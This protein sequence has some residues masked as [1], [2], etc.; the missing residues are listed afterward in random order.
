MNAAFP[1]PRNGRRAGVLLSLLLLGTGFSLTSLASGPGKESDFQGRRVLFMGIDGCRRDV[2]EQVIAD[3]SAPN[4]AKLASGGLALMNMEAGGQPLGKLNQPTISGPGWSTLL[5]G[6]FASK[7][8]VLGN[9]PKFEA[10]NFKDHPH[11]FRY[12]RQARPGAWLGSVVGDTWPEVNTILIQKSGTEIANN[13]AIVPSETVAEAGVKRRLNDANV[14]AE[15]VRCLSEENPDVLFLHF[16]DVDHAGHQFGFSKDV[17]QYTTTLRKLD[18]VIGAVLAA[19]QKRSE[20]SEESWLIIVS[21]D[22]GGLNRSHG[23]Q[24]PDERQIFAFFHGPG[25]APK[26][27]REGRTFQSVVTPTV[28]HYLGLPIDAA[29]GLESEPLKPGTAR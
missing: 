3:G 5:T 27:E 16:L 22:H 15:A 10:G 4:L 6:V 23:G 12:L 18:E 14:G 24:T 19:V 17:P 28:L 25:F 1:L 2:M 20:Y 21:T 29:W 11:F 13:L 7:H 8:G 26:Q 9:G